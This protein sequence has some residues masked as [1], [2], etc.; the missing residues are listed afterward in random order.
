MPIYL[1]KCTVPCSEIR[2]WKAKYNNRF[3]TYEK[4]DYYLAAIRREVLQASLV[5]RHNLPL[6]DFL[7]KFGEPKQISDEEAKER[8]IAW[9]SA[10]CAV[11]S[12]KRKQ[13]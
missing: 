8:V 3:S 11:G 10:I 13:R 4:I 2:L 7:L 6:E 1:I 9:A 12:E 5:K